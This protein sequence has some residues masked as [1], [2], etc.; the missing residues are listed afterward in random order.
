VGKSSAAF[1]LHDLLVT[2]DVK[3]AVIE[4]DALDL[5]WP[6]PWKHRLAARNL[7]AIWPNYRDLGYRRLIY[8]NTVAILEADELAAAMGDR[9]RVT[10]VLL[11]ASDATVRSRLSRRE[12]G[13]SLR[14]HIERSAT[15]A[16]V[17]D[18]RSA[19]T[20][21]RIG[22]NGRSVSEVA[23]ALLSLWIN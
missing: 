8:T 2:E 20:V 18:E 17:L 21:H 19:A 13:D 15:A 6:A 4:G 23:A 12:E 14:A 10:S 1:G 11:T 3:H 7:A 22:T 5:A 16:T 9:P